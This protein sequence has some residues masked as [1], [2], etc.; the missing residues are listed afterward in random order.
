MWGKVSAPSRKN[1]GTWNGRTMNRTRSLVTMSAG[2]RLNRS[3]KLHVVSTGARAA[4]KSVKWRHIQRVTLLL[5]TQPEPTKACS[6]L[7]QLQLY[8]LGCHSPQLAP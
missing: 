6:V 8:V 7:F 4:A 1:R 3:L 2:L 5:G